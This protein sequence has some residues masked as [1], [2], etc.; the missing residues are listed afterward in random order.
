MIGEN[1]QKVR[2]RVQATCTRAGRSAEDVQIVAVSKTFGSEAV[3]EAF[4]AG[5]RDFGENYVQE[6]EAKRKLLEDK[7]IRWHFI[8]RLQSNKVKF[9][10]H[11][12]DLI[13]SVD[14]LRLAQEIQKRAEQAGRTIGILIE[15]HTTDEATKSG[16]DP[17][18]VVP[19]AKEV[20]R[21]DHVRLQGLMTMGP[22]SDDP[23]DSRTSFRT[24]M[25]VR[26]AIEKEGI[27]NVSMNLLSM[28][29]THDFE[30]AIEEGATIIRVG[31]AIFGPRTTSP[32]Q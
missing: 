9:I 17:G 6:L 12:V 3:A 28:G 26:R 31:T 25:D 1:I 20:S 5:I 27:N 30:V 10:A 7:P 22:F 4:G 11:Y 19:L 23:N 24:V 18:D 8:G 21:L 32:K 29:M 13:H 15:V 16:A 14:N 2:A